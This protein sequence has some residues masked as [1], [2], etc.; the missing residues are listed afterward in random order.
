M[1]FADF[2]E[3][4][5]AGN[6]VQCYLFR[7]GAEEGEYFAYTAATEVVAIDHGAP[8]GSIDYYPVPVQRE[9]INSDGTLDKQALKLNLDVGAG[10]AEIFRIYP[11]SDVITLT[12]FEGH[13][14]DPDGEFLAVWGGR[15]VSA[16][17]EH[18]ELVLSGEP[19]STQLRRPGLRRHYQYGCTHLL[20]AGQSG[21]VG[22]HASKAA[23]TVTST[24]A[25]LS[26]TTVTL[27]SGWEGSK[28]PAKFQRGMVE[29][30]PAGASVQRRTILRV[31]G[32]VLTLAGLATNLD[33]G[34]SIDV[35]LGCNH[36]AF[37][38]DGD[39]EALHDVVP[40][41]GGQPW[42]PIKN[43]IGVNPFY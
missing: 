28:P 12:I 5:A 36:K 24:V 23:G 2:E 27:D 42:I 39:C 21:K 26:G 31:T 40:D 41:Y 33:V 30:T 29:W 37:A 35:V 17:R 13:L 38:P 15:I 19:V 4:R 6:P 34:D 16:S 11:P 43:V 18:G 20:Y 9:T 8:L 10:L 1:S 22:C 3:S 14:D 25:A 7:Y 32:D